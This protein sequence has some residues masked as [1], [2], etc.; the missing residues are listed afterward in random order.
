MPSGNRERVVDCMEEFAKY[1]IIMR[2]HFDLFNDRSSERVERLE[3]S[4]KAECQANG[5]NGVKDE[6]GEE[7]NAK[8]MASANVVNGID[9]A[10]I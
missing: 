7:G 2:S 5:A 10:G 6:A 3:K 1:T 4:R 8:T 9:V